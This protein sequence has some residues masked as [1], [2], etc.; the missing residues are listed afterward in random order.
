MRT[1]S[2]RLSRRTFL[3]GASSLG[4]LCAVRDLALPAASQ[5]KAAA[6]TSL[7]DF[8]R[9][10]TAEWVRLNPNLATAIRYFSGEEQERL[11]R[12]LT[13]ETHAWRQ[14]RIRLARRGL[15]A[16][17]KFDRGG[18]SE[19]ERVSADVMHWQLEILVAEESYL[20]YTFPLEQF[21]GANVRLPYQLTVVHPLLNEKDA[22]N[23][24]AALGKMSTRMEEAIG[25]G[26]GMGAK[27]IIPPRFILQAT[28]Q[29]M[30]GFVGTAPAQNA[31]VTAFTQKMTAI[32]PISETRREQLSAEA[33]KIVASQVYPAWMKAIALLQL[34]LTRASDD[35]GV[36]RF[37]VGPEIYAYG[38]R[39]YT[40]TNLTAEQIHEIGLQ[41]VNSIEAQMDGL[42]RRLGRTEGSVNSRI[43]KLSADLRYPN[44][45]S[46]ESRAQ[47]MKDID[48]ILS[49]AQRRAALLFDKTPKA[50]V[51]AQPYPRFSEANQAASY[52][53]PA[54]DGSRPGTFQFP[55]RVDQMTKFGLRSLVYHETVP[56]HHFQIALELEDAALPRF[57]QVRAFGGISAL[58]EGWGLYAERL[59]SESGWYE[60]DPEGLLGQLNYELFRAR[61]LVVDT[62]IHAK[63][64]TRQQGIE[65]GIEPSEVERYTVW[66]GQACSYMMGELKIIELREK[67]K[68]ALGGKFSLRQF[69]NFVLGAGTVPLD[70][71]AREVDA[72]IAAVAR[73]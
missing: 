22:D 58:T 73:A 25:E 39:R 28:I 4:A 1:K 53:S 55:R 59:A 21:N 27:G 67:A 63:R 49:D 70:V 14:D 69:H 57:R 13:P 44:P 38:L 43:E 29:Q 72:Y 47:I 52:T 36:W 10:F 7:E 71:L 45:A 66:P 11:E 48:A 8:F 54:I 12:Q 64:W 23:Y 46:E 56:G 68:K 5:G 50:P 24:V 33:Q 51:V 60:D 18:M 35:A 61:R 41:H 16:L 15:A 30:Q 6:A 32:K 65:Y 40:T 3:A 31:L 2:G 19:K 20:E 37:K 26:R 42:L 34:Q 17:A 9:D 62:G